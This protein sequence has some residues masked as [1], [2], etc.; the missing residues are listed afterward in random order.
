MDQQLHLLYFS[1]TGTT[2][3]VV[4]AIAEGMNTRGREYDLTMPFFRAR[5]ISYGENDVVIVGV[6]VYGGRLPGFLADYLARV[7][8]HNTP[9][10]FV[11]VY[12]NRNYDDA[13]LELKKIMEPNGFIGTAGAAFI[14]EHS[15]TS[16]VATGRPD[17]ADLK[18][19]REF[20]AKIIAK[21]ASLNNVLD[22]PALN[23][24]GNFPY[25]DRPP[26]LSVIPQ[27]N[28]I[29]TRCGICA[30]QCPM[31]AI[32]W[33]NVNDI[34]ADKCIQ[35]CSCVKRCPVG[36]VSVNHER[37]DKIRQMLIANCSTIRKE[38]EIFI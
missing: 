23:V 36:A 3:R 21:L 34:D 10:V 11:V 18:A 30:E 25:R 15:Y 24:K 20:G 37:I 14:G 5:D 7:K 31:Q 27:I 12:G 22:A 26:K 38:P 4:K 19:A 16:K 33:N 32:N 9:A 1:A 35:C 28:S 2:A 13:L 8:G 6:P 17:N 29:C